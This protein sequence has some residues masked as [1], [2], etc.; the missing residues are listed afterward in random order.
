M[1]RL[2]KLLEKEKGTIVGRW[3]DCLAATYP[4][5]TARFLQ[6]Q[7]DAFANPVGGVARQT[8]ADLFDEVTGDAD[9]DRLKQVLD[10]LVRIRA[11]QTLFTP[12]QA[13]AFI[14]MV[15][16]IVRD[17]IGGRLDDPRGASDLTTFEDK[18]DRA[19][20]TGFD[21][22]MSCREQIYRLKA[23]EEQSKIYKAFARAGLVSEIHAGAEDSS[24]T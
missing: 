6:S 7:T 5:D 23:T 4:P 24:E 20:L 3:F 9:P 12:A 17:R 21:V 2:Q 14:P 1:M 16:A 8:L 13:L 15:K 10:P 11:V 18:V 22:F 19:L